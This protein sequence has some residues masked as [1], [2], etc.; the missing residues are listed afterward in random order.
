MWSGMMHTAQALLPDY[1]QVV[2]QVVGVLSLGPINSTAGWPYHKI[3]LILAMI[4]VL[5][6]LK[7]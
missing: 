2:K 3:F 7:F 5:K 1:A 4:H 6:T